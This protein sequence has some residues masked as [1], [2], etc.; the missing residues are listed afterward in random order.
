VRSSVRTFAAAVFAAVGAAGLWLGTAVA[1]ADTDQAGQLCPSWHATS[2]DA[3]GRT[4]TCN[5]TMTAPHNLVWQ[6]GGP[7]DQS[8]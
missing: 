3:S 5:C 4:L 1:G 2:V 8:C 7:S 6:L